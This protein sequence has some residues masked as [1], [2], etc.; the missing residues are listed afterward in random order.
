MKFVLLACSDPCCLGLP[1]DSFLYSPFYFSILSFASAR[2]GKG[3]SVR[4]DAWPCTCADVRLFEEGER[5][6]S[7]PLESYNLIDKDNIGECLQKF[8][9]KPAIL[10]QSSEIK[11]K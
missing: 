7:F 10:P 2:D 9:D 4:A 11:K 5:L 1:F 6:G 3:K 8:G